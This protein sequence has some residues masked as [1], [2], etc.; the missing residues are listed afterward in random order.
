MLRALAGSPVGLAGI[1]LVGNGGARGYVW[2]NV[3]QGLEMRAVRG[4]A[5]GQIEGDQV[6]AA[7]RFCVDLGREAAA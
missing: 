4:F 6:S 5:A 7:V 1:A 3:E 2:P